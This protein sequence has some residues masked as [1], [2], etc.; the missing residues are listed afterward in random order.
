M[1][2][3]FGNYVAA[4]LIAILIVGTFYG[5]TSQPSCYENPRNMSCMTADQLKKELNQ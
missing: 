5:C 4:A 2:G 3:E 1:L